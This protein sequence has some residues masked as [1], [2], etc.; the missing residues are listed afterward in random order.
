MVGN[1]IGR[2]VREA[3][4]LEDYIDVPLRPAAIEG[5]FLGGGGWLAPFANSAEHEGE[6]LRMRLGPV[7]GRGRFAREVKVRIRG[8][9]YRGEASVMSLTWEDAQRPGLFP[10]LDGDLELSPLGA[11]SCRLTLSAT[12]TPP[13]GDLGADLDRALLH[14]VAQ[15]TVRSFLRQVAAS[16]ESVES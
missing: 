5:R 8:T 15:S 1:R 13:L 11:D 12:Y 16:L 2:P 4:F 9:R 14:Y 7:W 10:V 3:I 6:G